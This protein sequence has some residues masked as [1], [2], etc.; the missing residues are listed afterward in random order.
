[1][2]VLCL[3]DQK[4]PAM[5]KLHYYVLQTN[6]MLVMYI[7]EAEEHGTGLLTARTIRAMDSLTSAGLSDE[8][9][10]EHKE[11]D[12]E[13]SMNDDDDGDDMQLATQNSNNN[14]DSS[15]DD[16]QQVFMWLYIA[17]M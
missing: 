12:V 6:R 9:G 2:Q 16:D 13:T 3:A 11:N 14:N 4:S 1:M 7:T 10:S 8:S 17:F 5:D 15:D